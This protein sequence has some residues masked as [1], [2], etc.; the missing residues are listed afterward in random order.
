MADKDDDKG[1]DDGS[2]DSKPAITFKTEAD[3]LREIERKTKSSNAKAADEAKRALLEQLGLESDDEVPSIVE[4]V[5]KSKTA[6]TEADKL[7]SEYKKLTKRQQE[8]QEENASLHKWKHTA[9]KS[10]ALS[11]YSSKTV[12]LETL[13]TG[14]IEDRNRRGREGFRPQWPVARRG[15][16]RHLQGQAVPQGTGQHSGCRYKTGRKD[17]RE[18]HHVQEGRGGQVQRN[19]AQDTWWS[20][21][22]GHEGC[23]R[24][25]HVRI[26][27]WQV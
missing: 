11:A 15:R 3:F 9:I 18:A 20:N 14:R 12:D 7:N 22:A 2:K 5:K 24:G 19:S 6:A 4:A 1:T 23:A 16:G 25:R 27:T 26:S 8:L 10:K 21:R 17:R 13:T